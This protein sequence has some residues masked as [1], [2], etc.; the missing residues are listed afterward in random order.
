MG[1]EE[2]KEAKNT[3]EHLLRYDGPQHQIE[4]L[5]GLQYGASCSGATRRLQ[6]QSGARKRPPATSG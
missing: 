4:L 6:A 3:S 5:R 2:V 1:S